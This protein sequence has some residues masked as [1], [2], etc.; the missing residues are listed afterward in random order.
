MAKTIEIYNDRLAPATTDVIDVGT[1]E[2]KF[3]NGVF[4]G[5]IEA[6]SFDCILTL[7]GAVLILN[8]NVLNLI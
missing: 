3:R 8:G 7:N 2:K 4:S 6:A 1:I 5:D